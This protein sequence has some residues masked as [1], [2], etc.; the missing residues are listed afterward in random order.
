MVSAVRLSSFNRAERC[1][2]NMK[3]TRPKIAVRKV[4]LKL[5]KK[6]RELFATWDKSDC[7]G[8]GVVCADD[9]MDVWA[10]RYLSKKLY[11]LI[12]KTWYFLAW[13]LLAQRLYDGI[14]IEKVVVPFLLRSKNNR[15][16][17]V[18]NVKK[19]RQAINTANVKAVGSKSVAKLRK[20]Q[21]NPTGSA[22][23]HSGHAW[24]ATMVKPGECNRFATFC[25]K[26]RETLSARTG[27][28]KPLLKIMDIKQEVTKLSKPV[29]H[30]GRYYAMR[31]MVALKH[32]IDMANPKNRVRFCACTGGPEL[33]K[34]LLQNGP[35][36]KAR[37]HKL[38]TWEDAQNLVL[39]M[40]SAGFSNYCYCDLAVWLCLC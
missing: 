18:A 26:L 17:C 20:R 4:A 40:R 37:K 27:S 9:R 28:G 22:G 25:E 12:G 24:L 13:C 35:R 14:I 8:N 32:Q 2:G 23:G 6:H 39:G 33:W 19:I 5:R 11:A 34:W 1:S 36:L 29:A 15:K 21:C 30:T 10:G 31:T 16:F 38:E 3:Q 7:T